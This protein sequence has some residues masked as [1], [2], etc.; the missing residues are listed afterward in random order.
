MKALVSLF[1]LT[2]AILFLCVCFPANAQNS[3]SLLFSNTLNENTSDFIEYQPNKFAIVGWSNPNGWLK[4]TSRA[5]IWLIGSELDTSTLTF[6]FGDTAAYF[7]NICKRTDGTITAC[8][9]MYMPPDYEKSYMFF[10]DF[11][12]LFQIINQKVFVFDG[13]NKVPIFLM[14][15]TNNNGLIGSAIAYA[16]D[17]TRLCMIRLNDALD[18]VSNKFYSQ[19]IGL[20][21]DISDMIYSQDSSQLWLFAESAFSTGYDFTVIDT[22]F[23][24][25]SFKDFPKYWN[26]STME[27]QAY[28]GEATAKLTSDSTFIL[29]GVI[30]IAN[31]N[32]P[33]TGDQSMGVSEWDSTM[34]WTP[35][36]IIGSP[37]TTEYPAWANGIDFINP[38][39]IYFA[40]TY[41]M[42]TGSFYPHTKSWI[43][44]GMLNRELQQ[45][46]IHY[47]GGDAYYQAY[48]MKCTSDGGVFIVGRRYDYL[49]IENQDD[50][51]VLKLNK[52]GLI[53]NINPK[54]SFL[55]ERLAFVSPNPFTDEFTVNLLANKAKMN[56][57]DLSGR[58]LLTVNLSFGSNGINA[59]HLKPG[60]YVLKI[61]FENGEILVEKIIK[62]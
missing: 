34:V 62:Q 53:T 31:M 43:M 36:T 9:N 16:D 13:W 11:D 15:A 12:S 44:T 58:S 47:Y 33:P 17:S 2:G 19:S 4:S 30:T 20:G 61:Q 27:V 28:S 29:T 60:V 8:G 22:S 39:S 18:M 21:C 54:I 52:Q 45:Q 1:K 5:K 48:V 40:G 42:S 10:V 32:H 38:D 14:L 6:S 37:D 41:N 7:N 57:L 51:Y 59:E 26:S 3:Y 50:V 46:F 23:N 55:K 35:A 25:I 49:S 24:L 56:L